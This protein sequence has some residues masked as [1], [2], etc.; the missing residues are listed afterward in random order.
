M[1]VPAVREH[2]ETRPQPGQTLVMW[3]TAVG[4]GLLVVIAFWAALFIGARLVPPGRTREFVAFAPNCVI[5]IRRLR[6]DHRL[7]LRGR[8]ALGATLAYLVSPVQAIPNIIP[9]IGQTDDIVI[10][11]AA[12]RYTCRHLPRPDVEAAWPGDF[13]HLDRL[14]GKA[15]TTA[16]NEVATAVD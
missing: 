10:L 1:F 9:V 15:T 5:L 8:L 7:P 6:S 4:I 2:L 11:M 3:L 12:L 13:R 14:L 16:T